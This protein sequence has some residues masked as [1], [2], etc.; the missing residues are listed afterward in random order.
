M[1]KPL[2]RLIM[3]WDLMTVFIIKAVKLNNLVGFGV[4]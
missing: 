4:N 1:G 2:T 3:M